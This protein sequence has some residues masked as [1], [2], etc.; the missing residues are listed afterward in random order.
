MDQDF[1]EGHKMYPRAINRVGCHLCPTLLTILQL[2]G[3]SCP[4]PGVGVV[5]GEGP[6]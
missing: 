5:Y 2:N 1:R 4:A 6:E 3:S